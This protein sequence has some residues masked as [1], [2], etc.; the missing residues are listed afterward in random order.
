[1]IIGRDEDERQNFISAN[2]Y[3]QKMI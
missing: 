3:Q 1:L 2:I